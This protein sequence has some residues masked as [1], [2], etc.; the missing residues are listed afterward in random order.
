MKN[1][2]AVNGL[3]GFFSR[4]F[5]SRMRKKLGSNIHFILYT[6]LSSLSRF[7]IVFTIKNFV[8]GKFRH[9][10]AFSSHLS[11][12]NF[13]LVNFINQRKLSGDDNSDHND[14]YTSTTK[15]ISANLKQIPSSNHNGCHGKC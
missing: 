8:E 3:A 7:T 12:Q 1:P 13:K 6:F 4:Q 10:E 9:L 14:D 5:V 2:S 11:D 15:Y